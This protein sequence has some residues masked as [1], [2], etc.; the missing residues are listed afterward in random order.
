MDECARILVVDDEESIRT[1]LTAIL[2]DAGYIV[3]CAANGREAIAM[4]N[5]NFYN[6]ALIDYRL[7]DMEGT[8]LLTA[9]R[10]T[11]PPMVKIMVTGYPSMQNAIESVNKRADA[12]LMKPVSIEAMLST[13]S[14]LLR[15]QQETE[16]YSEKKVKEYIETRIRKLEQEPPYNNA[17]R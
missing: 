9:L 1:T 12:F 10:E 11:T 8:E 17:R 13:L 15:K 7:P 14:E 4:S 16:T 2:E 3:D 5:A 6:A